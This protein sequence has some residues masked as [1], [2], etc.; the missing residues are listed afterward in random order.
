MARA[1]LPDPRIVR[2]TVASSDEVLSSS[3]TSAVALSHHPV[4]PAASVVAL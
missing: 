3:G 2:F 4:M 1:M